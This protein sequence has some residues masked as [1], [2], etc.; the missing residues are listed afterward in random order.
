M[1]K[2]ETK[3]APTTSVPAVAPEAQLPVSWESELAALAVQTA[4]TEKP[5]SNWISFK[6]GQLSI[7]GNAVK[8]NKVECV[9]IHSIHE[10]QLY[11]DKYDPNN[12]S[13]P[14]CY[15]FA[16]NDDD[17]KPHPDSTTPQA[18]SCAECPN[19]VWGSDPGGGKGKA[20]KN[21]RRLGIMDKNDLTNIEK[22]EVYLAKLPVTSVKNWGTYA[23]QIANV[24]KLPP[25]AVITEMS[26]AP[27]AKTQFQVNFQLVDKVESS[28]MI[29]ALLKKRHDVM[30]LIY[31]PYDKYIEPPAQQPAVAGKK[32]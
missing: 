1:A 5:S 22:A 11:K 31:Q 16:D 2:P 18:A 17:L 19:N 3:P 15:A 9:V 26:T 10:N 7:N 6:S 21:V 4:E 32:Y 14:I 30:P 24:L 8:G 12:P 13:P 20:C 28:D 23:S 25:L 29:Q 27:D